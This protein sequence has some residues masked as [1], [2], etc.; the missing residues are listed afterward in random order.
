[1]A[2]V[3]APETVLSVSALTRLIKETL[4]DAFPAVWVKGEL[5]GFK[6]SDRGH[7]YFSMKEG[8]NALIDCVM[9]KTT[10]ARLGFEPRDGTEVE[11]FGAITVYEPRGRYQ[12]VAETLR[13]GGLGALLLALEEL[14][15]RLQAEGLFDPARKRPLPRYP[16]RIG[17]VTSPVGAAVRDLVK[18]LRA[19]WPSIG[20]VLAPVRVQG[21][22]AAEEIAAAIAAFNHY[23]KVDLLIVGRGGGSLEDLWAFNEEIVAR[24]I[25]A[26]RL[27]VISAVGHE[28]DWTLADWTA[29]VRAATP[30]NAAELAVRDH[31]EVRRS[32]AAL[33]ERGAR[34]L[35]AGLETRRVRLRLGY[36]QQRVDDLLERLSLRV[37]D[38]LAA[39]RDRLAAVGGRYGLR[40]WPRVLALRREEARMAAARLTAAAVDGMHARRLRLTGYEDRLRALAPMRVME[41]GYC[42]VRRRDGTLL[43]VADEVAVGDAITVEFARGQADAR[44]EAV[45]PEDGH[46]RE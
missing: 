35:R 1:M 26:S 19:R 34:A 4:G 2:T 9:W 15:R 14:K 41:R 29:D 38:A 36:W 20:I 27:P 17:L 45:H 43:R 12:L 13:P 23:L 42:L 37:R 33:R 40:E 24:A 30:S 44:V 32:V 25:A 21:Q 6:R 46:G 22:G 5:S 11:A 10:A 18:V 8:T 39:A 16:M 7:L 3:P 31:A 28:V